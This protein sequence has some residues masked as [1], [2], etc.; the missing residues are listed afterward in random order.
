M[1]HF[2]LSR[3]DALGA[4][5]AALLLPAT[6]PVRAHADHG[7]SEHGGVVAEAGAFQG[8]LVAGAAGLVLHLSDH[9]APVSA[10]G[11]TAKLTVLASG[12]KSEI[13]LAPAGGN[14]LAGPAGTR[15]PAGAKVVAA[16]RLADG[17]SGALR[18][19][20]K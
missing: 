10:E 8:E 12:Q 4:L 17:R 5:C 13:A 6:G 14:R 20:L 19:E 11:A 18:F 7:K 16:V 3:R 2:D 9:G 1:K 15:L